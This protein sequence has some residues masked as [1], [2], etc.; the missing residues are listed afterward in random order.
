MFCKYARWAACRCC[1]RSEHH[2]VSLL[3]ESESVLRKLKVASSRVQG[4][5][6]G[7]GV[8]KAGNPHLMQCFASMQ[9][10]QHVDAV[11]DQ[12]TTISAC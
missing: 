10:G 12:N 5:A 7:A 4:V 2:L 8:E 11:S 3:G 9:G 1:A 6:G